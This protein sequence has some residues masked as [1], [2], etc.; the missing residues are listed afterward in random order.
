MRTI[1]VTNGA[2]VGK[3]LRFG[4]PIPPNPWFTRLRL[5]RDDSVFIRRLVRSPDD[6]HGLQVIAAHWFHELRP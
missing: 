4:S 3:S 2:E 5:E 6:I 1:I